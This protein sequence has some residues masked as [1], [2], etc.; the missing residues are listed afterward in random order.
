MLV[1]YLATS[2]GVLFVSLALAPL[3]PLHAQAKVKTPKATPNASTP[4]AT[5]KVDSLHAD[6]QF[7]RETS[8]DNT[9]EI[10]LGRLAERKAT[11]ADVK[12]FGQRM[13][14]DHA[15]L[16]D[17][18]QHLASAGGVTIER[19]FGAKHEAKLDSLQKAPAKNFDR[20]YMTSMVVYHAEYVG[21]FERGSKEAHSAKLRELNADA[22]KV[23]QQHLSMAKEIAE[24]VGADT[25]S[26]THAAR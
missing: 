7:I 12:Q 20:A 16:E 9:L 13:V 8:A 3:S 1:R 17:Q 11:R 26:T 6:V 14:T 24:K 19:A 10:R 15:K 21:R 5:P 23:M 18:F 4:K 2:A 22:L 25:T